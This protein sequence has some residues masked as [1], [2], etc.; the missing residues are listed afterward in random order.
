MDAAVL[1]EL[2]VEGGCEDAAGP[3]EHRIVVTAG[4]D[5]D[6]RPEARD[7]RRADEDHL[8]GA[9]GKNSGGVEDDGVVL[10]AVGVALDCDVEHAEAALGRV[11][12][13]FGQENAAS[14]GAE[15]GFQA[16]EVIEGVVEAGALEMLEEGGG[17]AAGQD[18]AVKRGELLR[19]ADKMCGG[20]ELGQALRVNVKSALQGEDADL[21]TVLGG[22]IAHQLRVAAWFWVPKVPLPIVV[23]YAYRSRQ[24]KNP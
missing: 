15:D 4:K 12:H 22:V 11:C 21:Y 24:E 5:L 8:H 1:G 18:E 16:D 13:F 3:N 17:L 10:A 9:A 6:A 2:G 14:A 23:R 20:A 7:S 19:L